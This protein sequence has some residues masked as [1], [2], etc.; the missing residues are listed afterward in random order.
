MKY[1]CYYRVSTKQQGSS[2][3]GL[4][5]Q[6]QQVERFLDGTDAKVI[7]TYT[8]IESGAEDN[9]P[10]LEEA[11]QQC[12]ATGATLLVAHLSRLT[13]NVKFG[14]ELKERFERSNMNFRIL[15]PPCD[16]T[17]T[18]GINLTTIQHERE[19]IGRRTKAALDTLKDK[20]I[21][22][23]NPENL[24]DEARQ[25]AWASISEN[26]RNADAVRQAM[27]VIEPRRD[28]GESYARIAE[29][30]NDAGFRTREGKKFYPATVRRIYLRFTE[31]DN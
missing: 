13:R 17:L 8:E 29:R 23:G 19:E 2:G 5:A 22:L 12:E 9:R 6:R 31:D 7:D 10:I 3:L 4:K 30:L 14:F 21:K 26:A 15:S 11:I 25:K 28:Q 20:G 27:A 1:I 18:F 24:T 16:N